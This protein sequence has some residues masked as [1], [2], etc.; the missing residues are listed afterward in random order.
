[1]K[2][3]FLTCKLV[4][5]NQIKAILLGPLNKEEKIPFLLITDTD[6]IETLRIEKVTP[7]SGGWVYDLKSYNELALGHQFDIVLEGFTRVPLDVTNAIYFS[8]FEKKYTYNDTDLGAIYGSEATSFKVWAPLASTVILK[9]THNKHTDFLPLNRSINGTYELVVNGDLDGAEYVYLITNNGLTVTVTDPYAFGST[10]NGISSVVI[11]FKKIAIDLHEETLPRLT[12][13]TDAIIY[14]ASVRDLTSDPLTNVVN[15]GRFLGLIEEGI[16]T[17]QGHPIGFDYIRQ[18]GITHLQLLPIYDFQ[19]VDEKEPS[20]F[21]NWGYDPQQYFVPEGSFASD[22]TDPYSRIIDLKRLV[23]AYHRSGIKIVM[24]VVYNHVY[25]AHL[26]VF[27]KIVP[28]YYFRRRKDG[29][30]SNGSFCG[31]DVATEK[32]MVRKLII[33]SALHWVKTYG[34]D[35]FR[36]DLMSN[37][38]QTTAKL[39]QKAVRALK[40]DFMLYGEG[41]NMPTELKEDERSSMHHSDRLPEFAFFNDSFRDIIKGPTMDDKLKDRGYLLGASSYRL[42]F[43]FAYVGSCLDL[44]FPSKF[45]NAKQSINYVEC[46]DNGTLFDKM[47]AS[48]GNESLQTRLKRLKLINATTMLAFGIPFFHMGQEIGLSKNGDLNS[49]KSGDKVNR[50]DYRQLDERYDLFTYFVDLVK[51][52]KRLP[53]LRAETATEIETMIAFEDLDETGIIIHYINKDAIK[54]YKQFLIII[55]PSTEDHFYELDEYM[56]LI[57]SDKGYVEDREVTMK[58]VMIEGLSLLVFGCI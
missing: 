4:A 26:S 47:I 42:G 30:L 36:F 57:F 38:D 44:I 3:S 52:R 11:N 8:D 5:S 46:H 18:S 23:S 37:I 34:I 2:D 51:L 40:P 21:Y 20:R 43:K 7:I 24:D 55:N 25:H 53:F 19:T 39:L 6:K 17:E 28:S 10:L 1:M 12:R 58:Q 33:D 15:K 49:Y 32:P 9:L 50:Y 13:Y 41:W 31:N 45:A 22:L 56:T 27:E 54:P 48:N 29:R 14:E 35:G 16:T